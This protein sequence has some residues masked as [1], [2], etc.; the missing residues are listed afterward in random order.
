[1]LYE[2]APEAYKPVSAI[3]SDLE[4]HQLVQV[5]AIL[6]P[7]ITYKTRDVSRH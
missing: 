4:S 7:V 5:V 3:I 2:E 1:L 6:R